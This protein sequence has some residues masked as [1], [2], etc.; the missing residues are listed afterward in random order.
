MMFLYICSDLKILRP[1]DQET[2]TLFTNF[3]WVF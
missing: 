3:Y 2:N 1:N